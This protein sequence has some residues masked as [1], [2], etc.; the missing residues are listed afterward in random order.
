MY[1]DIDNN[2]PYTGIYNIQK[3][4]VFHGVNVYCFSLVF[5]SNIAI[6]PLFGLLRSALG[7]FYL[8]FY[9]AYCMARHDS[10]LF[11]SE[12]TFLHS[13]SGIY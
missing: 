10:G 9:L 5:D 6:R 13:E 7:N 2:S 4:D 11:N 8:D 1:V 12:L 3:C